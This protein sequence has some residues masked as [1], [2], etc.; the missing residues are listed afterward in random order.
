[1]VFDPR[2]RVLLS[3]IQQVDGISI[4]VVVLLRLPYLVSTVHLD[5]TSLTAIVVQPPAGLVYLCTDYRC[6]GFDWMAHTDMPAGAWTRRPTYSTVVAAAT[7]AP[8]CPL[9]KQRAQPAWLPLA[10][11]PACVAGIALSRPSRQC[12]ARPKH[13]PAW[14]L[15]P[16]GTTA[17]PA[18]PSARAPTH[19]TARA[20]A[21]TAC[22]QG[23]VGRL[24]I[25]TSL[26]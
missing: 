25:C 15:T 6:L 4:E 13:L 18:A 26:V 14:T 7:C 24:S 16:T 11:L 8:T 9:A 2:I 10:T 23:R 1:M 22:A 21:G 3:H 19:G 5:T 17:A 12:A 20:R